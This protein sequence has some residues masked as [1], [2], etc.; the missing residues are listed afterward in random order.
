MKLSAR[1][2]LAGQVKQVIAGAVNSEVKLDLDG[3]AM[4]V[5]IIT[6]SSAERLGLISGARAFAVIKAS[7]VMIG[8]DI[9]AAR[10]EITPGRAGGFI[11]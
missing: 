1:N 3:G 2:V 8:K 7:D 11:V 4:V 9:E 10:S 5:A 6:N